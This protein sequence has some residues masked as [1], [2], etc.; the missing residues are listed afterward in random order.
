MPFPLFWILILLIFILISVIDFRPFYYSPTN[1]FGLLLFL[2]A[3]FIFYKRKRPILIFL[4]N[5]FFAITRC[6]FGWPENIWFNHLFSGFSFR[7]IFRIDV[8]FLGKGKTLGEGDIKL[9]FALGW[10]LGWPDTIVALTLSFLIGS[11]GFCL[12]GKSQK[13]TMKDFFCLWRHF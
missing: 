12:D 11:G 5:L 9:G 8:F 7:R 6:F 10:L 1:W 3:A 2:G 4:T 13:K